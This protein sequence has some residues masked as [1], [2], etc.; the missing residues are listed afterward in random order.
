MSPE[1]R[2]LLLAVAAVLLVVAAAVIV[3][4][5]RVTPDE[6]ERRRR[7][8]LNRIG[9]MT[10]GLITDVG[11]ETLYYT[12]SVMGVEYETSQDVSSLGDWVPED[13]NLLIGPATLKYA[14]RNPA[15]SIVLCEEWSGLRS[16]TTS[17]DVEAQLTP[18]EST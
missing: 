3:Y 18:E 7:E 2:L 14:P 6:R 9:R 16:R 17:P 5:V 12:Y 8:M 10:D 11:D 13:R 4:R 15:N 1:L